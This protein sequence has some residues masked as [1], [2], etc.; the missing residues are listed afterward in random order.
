MIPDVRAIRTLKPL[1]A[2]SLS[3]LED[4]GARSTYTIPHVHLEYQA[5]THR[6]RYVVW[7]FR[8][9]VSKNALRRGDSA[10]YRIHRPGDPDALEKRGG[11]TIF[12]CASGSRALCSGREGAVQGSYVEVYALDKRNLGER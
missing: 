7:S 5:N 12:C 6:I 4:Q 2:T 3:G 10:K 9:M 1:H 8:H 11:S